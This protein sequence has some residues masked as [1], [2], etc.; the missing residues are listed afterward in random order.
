M[1]INQSPNY[2]NDPVTI[3]EAKHYPIYKAWQTVG[4]WVVVYLQDRYT[5]RN[6]DG[7]KVHKSRQNAYKKADRLNH[8]IKYALK[9]Y[10]MAE[11]YFDGNTAIVREDESYE[12]GE[13]EYTLSLQ[14]AAMPPY[15]V[16]TFNT[17]VEVETEI[18]T[19]K[20][21]GESW[22]ALKPEEI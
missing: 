2:A 11:C 10:G 15:Y 8:P 3:Y 22:S 13:K 5:M 1:T 17:L 21:R 16:R 20:F 19:S 6:V 18:E 14:E 12:T 9:K 7:G 4:G